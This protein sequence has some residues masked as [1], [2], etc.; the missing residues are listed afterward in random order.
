[1]SFFA[2]IFV[3]EQTVLHNIQLP[4]VKRPVS[5]GLLASLIMGSI[6]WLEKAGLCGCQTGAD[7]EMTQGP[8]NIDFS[9]FLSGQCVSLP[10]SR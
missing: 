2:V 10:F 1:M 3:H 6:R 8:G 9:I 7:S 4:H 5:L